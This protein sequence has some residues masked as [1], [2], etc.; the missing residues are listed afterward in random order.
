MI[1]HVAAAVRCLRLVAVA[2]I[3]S[4]LTAASGRGEG[5]VWSEPAIDTWAYVNGFGGGSRLLAPSFGA[6]FLDQS[7]NLLALA[8]SQG[9]TRLGSMIVA[10]QT[11]DQVTPSL[12]PSRYVVTSATVTVR[13]QSGSV[14][15]LPY[16]NSA[17]TPSGLL[18]EALGGGVTSQKPFELFGVGFRAGYQGFALGPNA[19][20]TRFA[21]S[22]PVNSGPGASY[23]A[24]PI[25]GDGA[26]GYADVA[27]NLTGGFSATAPGNS[28]APFAATPWAIGTAA[29]A[30]GSPLPNDTTVTFSLDLL[31]PGVLEYLRRSLSE[32]S[33]GFFLT[34]LHPAAQPG[35]SGAGSY[36]QWYAKEAVG[37]Y[38]NAEPATLSLNYSILPLAG[39]Y[40]GNDTVGPADYEAWRL[41]Y[42]GS[43]SPSGLGADGNG[44]GLVNAADYVVWR[45]AFDASPSVSTAVPEPSGSVLGLGLLAAFSF[46]KTRISTP[47]S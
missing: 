15:A 31:Q 9:P 47:R 35:G 2:S 25:V 7:T 16:S 12:A 43:V 13:V 8:G 29:I 10:F 40:D 24:Y 17:V 6:T 45:D 11:D 32:G 14:G 27:N 4:V 38:P 33:V 23:V 3:A 1:A 37:I 19:T 20:G 34:S 28:T 46:V 44:D 21:E 22:T 26:G 5:A 42:G 18:A 39:D 30:P 36:P 41:A